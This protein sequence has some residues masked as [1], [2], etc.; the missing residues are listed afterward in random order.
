MYNYQK[1]ATSGAKPSSMP[2]LAATSC[3]R[4]MSAEELNSNHLFDEVTYGQLDKE[5]DLS[6]AEPAHFE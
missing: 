2:F 6:S 3:L 1:K 4:G 5:D